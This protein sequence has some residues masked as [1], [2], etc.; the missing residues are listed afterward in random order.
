M[1]KKLRRMAGRLSAEEKADVMRSLF[2]TL[3]RIDSPETA[4][5]VGGIQPIL[6]LPADARTDN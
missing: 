3:A 6:P 1:L 5:L 2:P 4:V